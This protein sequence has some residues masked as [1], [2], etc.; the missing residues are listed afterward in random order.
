MTLALVMM[1]VAMLVA[2]PMAMMKMNMVMDM[3]FG[4]SVAHR[5]ALSLH[6]LPC[7]GVGTQALVTDV[8]WRA[9]GAAGLVAA[10]DAG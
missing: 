7:L 3:Y 6:P 9:S 2:L 4:L 10:A 5:L 1:Q 8:E